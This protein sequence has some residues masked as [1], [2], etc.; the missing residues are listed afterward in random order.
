MYTQEWTILPDRFLY[1]GIFN[2]AKINIFNNNIKQVKSISPR[3]LFAKTGKKGRREGG[4][5]GGSQSSPWLA[6]MNKSALKLQI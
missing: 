3:L 5:E 2:N 4:R 1:L 6:R